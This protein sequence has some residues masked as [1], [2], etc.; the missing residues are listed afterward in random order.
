MEQWK[1]IVGYEGLY[2]V[3]NIGNIRRLPSVIRYKQNGTRNYPGKD[4]LQ[5]RIVEGY[6]R[7]VLSKDG[8]KKRYMSHRI[9]AEAFI[10]NLDNKKFVNHINGNKSD[11][12]VENLEWCTPKYN[13]NYGNARKKRSRKVIQYTADG[14]FVNEYF[15]TREAEK[16]TGI[17]HSAIVC[18][19][20][21]RPKYLTAGGYKWKYADE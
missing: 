11:N 21:N 15:G 14:E 4:L 3:S 18:C 10:P 2:E 7:V 8:V 6:L 17:R 5:E 12:R 19:C 1:A 16:Q 20:Q 13:S 9:V